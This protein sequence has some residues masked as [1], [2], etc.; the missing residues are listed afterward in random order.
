LRF[1]GFGILR[2]GVK[3]DYPFEESLRSLSSLTE[4]VYLALG[5]S[6][7]GTENRLKNIPNLEIINTNWD[8]KLRDDGLILSNQTN[9]I[10]NQ[11]RSKTSHLNHVWGVYLQC[12]E[13][14]LDQEV[15]LILSDIKQA[16]MQGCDAVNF[17]YLHFWQSFNKI[18]I[19]KKWYPNE[20]RAIKLDS[21]IE[22][23]GDAQS[24]RNYKKI[25]YSK[26]HIFHYGH[27]R[28]PEK[29]KLKK[30]DMLKFYHKD[31]KLGK[32]RE[33]EKRQDSK[34]KCLSYFGPHPILMKDRI[35]SL[36]GIFQKKNKGGVLI[37][38][39]CAKEALLLPEINAK[40][41]F[42]ID[43]PCFLKKISILNKFIFINLKKIDKLIPKKAE[44]KL[45][46]PWST[47]MKLILKLSLK[48]IQL[49]S[50][51]PK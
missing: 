22:S 51:A 2:N 44:S 42:V 13:L 11:L 8:P 16:E 15:N 38:G 30:T 7:D 24:F 10:L 21:N 14:F 49:K 28:S 6:E 3:Y 20:I 12:D 26:A 36:D 1:F 43:R 25:F 5:D 4:K 9:F 33:K 32:Y 48:G 40:K 37:T 50:I 18:A 17:R 41:I 46:F 29:Y 39:H 34:T 35:I 45:A 47:E 23:W 19:N 27:V 31:D